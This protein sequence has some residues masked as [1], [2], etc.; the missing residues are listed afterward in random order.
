MHGCRIALLPV[1]L[2][3]SAAGLCHGSRVLKQKAYASAKGQKP[4][5]STFA[6]H[7]EAVALSKGEGMNYNAGTVILAAATDDFPG[8]SAYAYTVTTRAVSGNNNGENNQVYGIHTISK[9]SKG[10]RAVAGSGTAY[11]LAQGTTAVSNNRNAYGPGNDGKDP[12][13]SVAFTDKPGVS[14]A[15]VG[16]G[17]GP[18]ALATGLTMAAF[19]RS[20]Y[21]E[22]KNKPVITVGSRKAGDK[23]TKW[24]ENHPRLLLACCGSNH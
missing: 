11:T 23:T 24:F 6:R 9:T 20:D 22:E 17:T 1:L 8:P 4:G 10:A 3:L 14:V 15:M 12:S 2:L 21:D 7:A 16:S 19:A 5:P 13:K 18:V